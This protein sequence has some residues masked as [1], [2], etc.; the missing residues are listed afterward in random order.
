MTEVVNVLVPATCSPCNIILLGKE[1]LSHLMTSPAVS[2]FLPLPFSLAEI[3]TLH[4]QRH[5]E[6]S[7][8]WRTQYIT[9]HKK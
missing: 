2:S 4:L 3:L 9:V 1:V 7:P 8:E 6:K 5:K